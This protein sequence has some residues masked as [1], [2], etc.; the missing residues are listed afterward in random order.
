MN[1]RRQANQKPLQVAPF[2]TRNVCHAHR[3]LSV[4][5][6]ARVAETIKSFV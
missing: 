3:K 1:A 6:A 5:S 4:N 2:G